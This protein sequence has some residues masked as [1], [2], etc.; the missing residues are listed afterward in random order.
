MRIA[1]QPATQVEI[2]AELQAPFGWRIAAEQDEA[3]VYFVALRRAIVGAM[4]DA[5]FLVTVPQDAHLTLKLE[6]TRL[7]LENV[8]GIFELSPQTVML[9]LPANVS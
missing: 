6:Q 7:C 4:A 8:N 9:R 5:S 1:R 2:S 3:G